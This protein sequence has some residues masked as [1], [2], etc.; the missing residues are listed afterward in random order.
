MGTMVQS[1]QFLCG[2]LALSLNAPCG[3]LLDKFVATLGLYDVVWEPPHLAVKIDVVR[4]G[5]PAPMAAGTFLEC[6][7][8]KVDAVSPGLR[9]T[10][11]SGVAAYYNEPANSWVIAA[12]AE[13]DVSER[14]EDIED[15]L[16]LVLTA[17]W[18]RAGWLPMHA[19]AVVKGSRC[20]FLCAPSGGGKTSLA[21][22]LIR[23]EWRTL[24]DDK[25]LLRIGAG[26]TLELAA[27]MHHF[28]LHPK[29]QEWFAE[30]GDLRQLPA[31][32][33]WTEKRR[34]YVEDIWS[35]K[36]AARGRP[37]HLVS[38]AQRE[39]GTGIK[40]TPLPRAEVLSTLLRQTAVPR[41]RKIA[42]EILSTVA[43]AA[44]ELEG[45]RVE[46]GEE[47]YRDPCGLEN[48]ERALQ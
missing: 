43:A 21:A 27:L 40:I 36:A 42:G 38:L 19:A 12:P 22:A 39:G 15:L 31:Y 44:C 35:G 37:T 29:A 2:P 14:P 28:N 23:R 8:M 33:A 41:D 4:A 13:F 17:G 20:V 25:V 47:V 1:G 45:L 32:S 26:Q 11:P 3:A 24:G 6:A 34:V 7:R 18:R 5:A 30:V 48:L 46:I 9:A 16:S 10:C